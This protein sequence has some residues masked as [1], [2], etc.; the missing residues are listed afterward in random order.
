[1][2]KIV[3]WLVLVLMLAG[4]SMETFN[5]RRDLDNRTGVIEIHRC[6]CGPSA[7]RYLIKTTDNRDTLVYN[8][9]NLPED[10]KDDNYKIA[11][12]AS[13]LN[14]SS[15]VYT[16][17]PTDAV[18]EDFRVRNIKLYAIRKC[19]TL[20]LNDTIELTY[21]NIYRNYEKNISIQL[22]SVTEDSRC[23]YNVECIWAGNAT[24][25]FKFV[26]NNT[27]SIIYLNT[28]GGFTRDTIISGYKIQFI[29]LKPYPVF[30]NPIHQTDYVADIKVTG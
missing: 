9:V 19:S 27:L 21:G 4:C 23:P 3:I 17:T 8:P 5:I 11:F 7:Y 13:L 2:K 16:N 26:Q 12:S 14:D 22:D 28:S 30:P 20:T 10:Y 6:F 18:I 15:I 25:K 1:M 24:A 29:H